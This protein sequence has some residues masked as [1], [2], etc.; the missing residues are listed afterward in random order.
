MPLD[1]K[2]GARGMEEGAEMGTRSLEAPMIN[3]SIV[4]DFMLYD[5]Q[6]EATYIICF[7]SKTNE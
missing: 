3:F 4:I 2:Q 1:R 6:P 5:T 7:C